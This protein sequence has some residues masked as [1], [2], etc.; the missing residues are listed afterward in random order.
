MSFEYLYQTDK[1]KT[2]EL[3]LENKKFPIHI[4]IQNFDILFN[5]GDIRNIL[6]EEIIFSDTSN[7]EYITYINLL[8]LF[9]NFY[10][11]DYFIDFI[12]KLI[13]NT[14][15]EILLEEKRLK[16]EE[17]L[18]QNEKKFISNLKRKCNSTINKPTMKTKRYR[19][20]SNSRNYSNNTNNIVPYEGI[21]CIVSTAEN[22]KK[23]IF[24]FIAAENFFEINN[25]I[26][27]SNRTKK[28]K[29]EICKNYSCVSHDIILS[30]IHKLLERY[31]YSGN[32]H[33]NF[34]YEIPLNQ[35]QNIVE[36]IIDRISY[37]TQTIINDLSNNSILTIFPN[38]I[39][40]NSNFNNVNSFNISNNIKQKSLLL[41]NEYFS[42]TTHIKLENYYED[43]LVNRLKT[44]I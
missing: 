31:I 38:N 44:L 3:E 11:R 15:A 16:E 19:P 26:Q 41:Q 14:K 23:N 40:S 7:W 12:N 24:Q 10:R 37:A 8:S 18:L 9:D 30:L 39:K 5:S 33:L 35:L 36:I 43:D 42:P 6:L 25:R 29:I 27:K 21:I 2:F 1:H 4:K 32:N 20:Y 28:S 22:I 17:K 34:K 13:E